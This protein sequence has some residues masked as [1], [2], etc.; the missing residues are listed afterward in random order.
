M[1]TEFDITNWRTQNAMTAMPLW[2]PL[3]TYW[4]EFFNH[5]DFARVAGSGNNEDLYDRK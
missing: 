5:I 1:P 3:K 2:K 4:K